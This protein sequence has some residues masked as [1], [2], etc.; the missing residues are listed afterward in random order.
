MAAVNVS[1]NGPGFL[2]QWPPHAGALAYYVSVA[3]SPSPSFY[4]ITSKLCCPLLP[5]QQRPCC[6]VLGTSLQYE[7]GLTPGNTYRFRVTAELSEPVATNLTVGES[8]P[9]VSSDVPAAPGVPVL[10][11]AL[12]GVP[13][14]GA[15][16]AASWSPPTHDG[17][18]TIRGYRIWAVHINSL[19][20]SN[21]VLVGNTSST[22]PTTEWQRSATPS[23]GTPLALLPSHSY[24]LAVQAFNAVG[25]GP[26][27]P[28]LSLTTPAGPEAAFELP[29]HCWRH[30]RVGRGGLA[31]HR[32]FLP[33]GSFR[34]RVVVQQSAST[35]CCAT[36]AEVRA[37]ACEI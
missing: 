8:N 20:V 18:D 11:P 29:L 25:G 19:N 1:R 36:L 33:V 7:V 17:G 15:V 9:V 12:L 26:L 2:I 28:T 13:E 35:A 24:S 32:V 27:G 22:R 34:A 4:E 23:H 14:C 21:L 5:T 6:P 3:R 30:G 31:R 37:H 16:Y 10:R